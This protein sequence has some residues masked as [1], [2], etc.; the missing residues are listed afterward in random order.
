MLP[1]IVGEMI[2]A[3]DCLSTDIADEETTRRAGHFITSFNLVE[4]LEA[5]EEERA[6]SKSKT[7]FPVVL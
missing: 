1:F 2:V 5:E 4:S 6:L 3:I 7:L